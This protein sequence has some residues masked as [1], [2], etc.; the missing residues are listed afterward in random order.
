METT[1]ALAQVELTREQLY[2][3]M[4]TTPATHVAKEFGL[5]DV[6]LA[7]VCKRFKIPRPERG[8]WA[9]IAAGHK[10]DR[11][12]LPAV[13][14][15]EPTTI[16]FYPS[17]HRQ[18]RTPPR[19]PGVSETPKTAS[20]KLA[21]PEAKLH[22]IAQRAELAMKKAKIDADGRFKIQ[23]KDLPFIWASLRQAGRIVLAVDALVQAAERTGVVCQA[24]DETWN[25]TLHFIKGQDWLA[26]TIEESL[27]EVEREPTI[28]EKRRPSSTWKLKSTHPSSK[29]VFRLNAK[30][31][32]RGR[33]LWS[34]SNST[35][36]EELLAVVVDRMAECF[37]YFDAERV[38]A[39]EAAKERAERERVWAEERKVKEHQEKLEKIAERR[40]SNLRKASEWWLL[41]EQTLSFIQNCE[42]RWKASGSLTQEQIDW[43][44]WA[45]ERAEG[46]SPH[47][48]GFPD[49]LHDGPFD[50]SPVAIGGPYPQVRELPDPPSTR[51][52]VTTSSYIPHYSEPV[53]QF[54]FWL[55]NRR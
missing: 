51:S 54:P 14:S 41:H 35:S 39:E 17:E 55:R 40:A 43:L 15:G 34:E 8:H 6:G 5:S 27:V 38:K 42:D 46:L 7:K 33:K 26:V 4:W 52:N 50:G 49:A 1:S 9:R 19:Q 23:Q 48:I 16:K 30:T 24:G 29:L 12:Q 32:L 53:R 37:E 25:P 28:E 18:Q 31:H 2:A 10:I 3:K 44:A 36:L 11:P 13:E 45:R 21:S 20:V 22:P 47:S